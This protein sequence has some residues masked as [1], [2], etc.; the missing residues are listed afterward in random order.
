MAANLQGLSTGP[1]K[2]GFR[3]KRFLP[4]AW[5]L[6]VAHLIYM[7]FP[8]LPES[9]VASSIHTPMEMTVGGSQPILSWST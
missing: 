4:P 9:S 5:I 7:I 2:P 3:G 1:E 6:K 8:L